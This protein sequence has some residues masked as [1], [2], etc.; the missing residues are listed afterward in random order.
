ME[1]PCIKVC[2]IDPAT[3]YCEGCA[4]TLKEIAKWGSLSPLDRRQI[5]AELAGRK[6][7]PAPARAG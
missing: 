1:S 2:I 6:P 3:G 5:M 4:R 7:L